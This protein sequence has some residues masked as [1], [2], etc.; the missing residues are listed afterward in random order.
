[1]GAW[2]A[3]QRW[4]TIPAPARAAA[5]MQVLN[6]IAAVHA[7]ARSPQTRQMLNALPPS[8]GPATI[9][10]TGR[11][12]PPVEAA[13][14]NAAFS[15]V[16]DF[17][18]IIWI[19]HTCHSAVFAAL[20]VAEAEGKTSQD[21]I[22][23]VVLANEIAG[24]IGGSTFLGPLNGQMWTFIHLVAAAAATAH[25]LEL[26]AERSTHAL[27]IA[28]AQPPLAL[29]PGFF[30]PTSKFLAAAV[31]TQIGVQAAYFARAGMT[32]AADILEDRKGFWKWFAFR[33]L[34]GV[35]SDLGTWWA[36]QTLAI[37]TYPACNYFQTAC[38][39]IERACAGR[40]PESPDEVER[41]TI[42][43]N[44]LAYE[45]MGFAHEYAGGAPPLLTALGVGFDLALTA[46]V[47]LHARRLTGDECEEAWLHEHAEPLRRWWQRIEVIHDPALTIRVFDT[48]WR[49]PAGQ[50]A[51]RELGLRELWRLT[52]DYRTH[53]GST[54][55]SPYEFVNWAR[56]AIERMRY[57]APEIAPGDYLPLY[58]PNRITL[59]FR[60]G[61]QVREQVDLQ[62]GSMAASTMPG[63]LEDKFLRETSPR[64]GAERARAAFAAGSAL[65]TEPLASFVA[66][67]VPVATSQHG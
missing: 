40:W 32:G 48:P 5:R 20:A 44:K 62:T 13:F 52:S 31:P 38:T 46:A 59:R 24:R 11:R 53:Y 22:A 29:Q 58:F 54:L 39:A 9:I 60:N 4:A 64:L 28:L 67:L 35:L 57:G 18:D 3:A 49:I 8:T 34:P 15:M 14:V 51:L 12:V 30:Q 16:Q 37:K 21:M 33:P 27:A 65:E 55:A 7:S 42:H 63:V 50:A 36:M 45:A 23:A 61:S 1:M 43:T 19:G 41:V 26:D 17:D 10:A 47:L 6:M 56:V 2:L 66:R 25:L